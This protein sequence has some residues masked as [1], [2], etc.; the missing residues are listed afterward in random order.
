[1]SLL[2][3]YWSLLT[4]KWIFELHETHKDKHSDIIN[5]ENMVE[6]SNLIAEPTVK[7]R[8]QVIS[9]AQ[10]FPG[11]AITVTKDDKGKLN[12]ID[13]SYDV[14]SIAAALFEASPLD[15]VSY[16]SQDFEISNIPRGSVISRSVMDNDCY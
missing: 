15:P 1:M 12:V 6:M 3:W 14:P 16:L 9:V 5:Q 7:G 13:R 11:T 2:S 4:E 8:T 10:L